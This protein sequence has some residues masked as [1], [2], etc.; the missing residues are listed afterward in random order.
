MFNL[1]F[2]SR[3]PEIGAR[4]NAIGH[5]ARTGARIDST[6]AD[7]AGKKSDIQAIIDG[8]AQVVEHFDRVIFVVADRDETFGAAE[9]SR[10]SMDI[11]VGNIGDIVAVL[12]EPINHGEFPEKKF[13]RAGGERGVEDLAIFAVGPIETDVNAGTPVPCVLAVV[14]E[15]ELAGPAIVG[16]P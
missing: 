11:E 13:A 12:L 1:G 16:L 8:G 10:V 9:I 2:V 3:A 5:A 6:A 7:V 15:G 4:K 14:V